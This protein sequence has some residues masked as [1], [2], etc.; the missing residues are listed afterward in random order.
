METPC[1]QICTINSKDFCT[2][3]KRT[4]EEI[5]KWV[6]MTPQER[7]DIINLLENRTIDE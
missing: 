5:S 1:V 4:R 2:G 3:C 7:K 6:Y